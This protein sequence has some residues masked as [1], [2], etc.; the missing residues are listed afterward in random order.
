MIINVKNKTWGILIISFLLAMVSILTI[1]PFMPSFYRERQ[2]AYFDDFSDFEMTGYSLDGNK[3]TVTKKNPKLYLPITEKYTGVKVTFSPKFFRQGKKL[4]GTDV[5]LDYAERNTEFESTS[6]VS[7][8]A[9]QDIYILDL[10]LPL[11]Q[12]GEKNPYLMIGNNKEYSFKLQS[13]AVFTKDIVVTKK[14]I[15][16]FVMLFIFFVAINSVILKYLQTDSAKNSLLIG[17]VLYTLSFWTLVFLSHGGAVSSYLVSDIGDTFLDHF[18]TISLAASENPYDLSYPSNYPALVMLFYRFLAHMYPVGWDMADA[19]GLYKSLHGMMEYVMLFGMLIALTLILYKKEYNA[20]TL[21]KVAFVLSGPV[22]F[23]I[24]RGNS[25]LIAFVLSLFFVTFYDSNSAIIREIAY[26]AL[27]TAFCIKLYPAVFGALLL[28]E[29]KYKESIRT[30]VY[31]II[32]FVAPFLYFGKDALYGFYKAYTM[33]TS[34]NYGYGYNYS[35]YNMLSVFMESIGIKSYGVL[36]LILLALLSVCMLIVM[37]KNQSKEYR[38]LAM[39]ISLMLIP[40]FSYTYAGIFLWIPFSTY[41]NGLNNKRIRELSF[42][43]SMHGVL[44]FLTLIPL[45]TPFIQRFTTGWKFWLSYGQGM[46][47]LA[48]LVFVCE[49]VVSTYDSTFKTNGLKGSA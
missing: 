39:T 6:R 10:N 20:S 31:G 32:L 46:Q 33:T 44:Y 45:A 22:I 14:M 15:V 29:K 26:I 16:L 3:F 12:Y 37:L 5:T 27:A 36:Y 24:E 13:V 25:I 1:A 2:I 40:K 11:G 17:I 23:E 30:A 35:L 42:A 7:Y 9:D 8:R 47:Y 21:Y 34:K 18:N 43:E 48:L 38:L 4:E 19:V 28:F 49:L 41:L